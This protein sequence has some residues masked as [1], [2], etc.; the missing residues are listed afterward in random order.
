MSTQ[1]IV[2]THCLTV[3]EDLTWELYVRNRR[4]QPQMCQALRSVPQFLTSD[5]LNNLLQLLDRLHVCCGQPDSHFISMVNAKK[6]KIISSDGK[7][8]ASIH[9]YAP[10]AV[11]GEH[12][13]ATVRMGSC[14][15]VSTSQKCTSCKSYRDTLRAMYN[16]WCKR[17]TCDLS[18]TSSHS[19][20][21]YLSTPEKKAKMSK[22]KQRVR[23]AEKQVQNLRAKIKELTQQQGD[24]VDANLNADLLGIMNENYEN[25]KQAYPEES[26]ARLFWEEQL[27]AAS[28]K[29]ARQICWHP[30]MIKWCLNLKLISSAA[31]H[32]VQT[33]GFLRLP[34]ERTLRDYTHY[35]KSQAGFLPDLN[36]QLQNEAGI[37]SLPES[38]RYVALLIDEMKIN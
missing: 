12:Y 34:S 28:V 8:A 18:D 31:Y 10:I 1:P 11:N 9:Q 29:D 32:T 27:K 24:D 6:G 15:M 25:I 20:E 37:D 3:S 38:K 7:V 13:R 21:R 33:S 23:V 17:R 30:L 22:L 19:N 16:R 2:I 26:F 5:S 35:F 14:E 4:V 36:E